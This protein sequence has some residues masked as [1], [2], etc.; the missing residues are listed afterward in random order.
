MSSTYV[1]NTRSRNLNLRGP[2][3]A[4]DIH[5]PKHVKLRREALAEFIVAPEVQ[6]IQ[7]R[8]GAIKIL[9]EDYP[10]IA[11]WLNRQDGVWARHISVG[12]DPLELAEEHAVALYDRA[13][14]RYCFETDMLLTTPMG[15]ATAVHET[16]HAIADLK[17]FPTLLL[18]EES[19]A[20]IAECWYLLNT[21]SDSFWNESSVFMEIAKRARTAATKSA[22]PV[23]I[24]LADRLA[25]RAEA[26]RFGYRGKISFFKNGIHR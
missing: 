13:Q 7:F 6:S 1:T 16:V 24:P 17:S 15:R 26:R 19:A 2:T 5:F 12:V 22:F 23:K 4:P 14:D 21:G 9:A 18:S 20:Y 11:F 25:A 8:F 3:R 10:S